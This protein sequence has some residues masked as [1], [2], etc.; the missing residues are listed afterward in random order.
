MYLTVQLCFAITLVADKKHWSQTLQGQMCAFK[1]ILI[2]YIINRPSV[3]GAVLQTPQSLSISVTDAFP[4]NH[5]NIITLKPFELE[6]CH[7]DIYCVSRVTCHMSKMSCIMYFWSLV[8]TKWP[9]QKNGMVASICICWEIQCLLYAG[10]FF[11]INNF[12][13]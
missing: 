9:N 7:F 4:S 10:F 11:M 1:M 6:G 5:L 8:L 3:A 13:W 2:T 12:F